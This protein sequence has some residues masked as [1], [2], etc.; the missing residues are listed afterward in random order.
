MSKDIKRIAILVESSRAYGRGLIRG[1]SEFAST[2]QDWQLLYRES[3]MGQHFGDWLE[4]WQGDGIITRINS[5]EEA[6]MIANKGIPAVD[7]YGAFSHPAIS[8]LDA[9]HEAISHVAADFYAHT[10]ISNYAYCGYPGVHFSDVRGTAFEEAVKQQ[11]Q[12]LHIYSSSQPA[13]PSITSHEAWR[14]G[15]EE[16]IA[17]WLHSLPKPVAVFAC[18]DVRALDVSSACR[19]AG[20]RVPE[21]VSIMGVDDDALICSMSIPPLTS[22]KP[23]LIRQGQRGAQIL[24]ELMSERRTEPVT[25]SVLPI[26]VI[27]RPSTDQIVSKYSYV[28]S[29]LRYLRSH[30]H[31]AIGVEDVAEHAG[32]SRSLIDRAFIEELGY[33]VSQEIRRLRLLRIEHLLK[34]TD[35]KLAG[36]AQQTGFSSSTSLSNFFKSVH[37]VSPGKFRETEDLRANADET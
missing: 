11:H 13:E 7:L 28:V 35:M 23:D 37:G 9:D 34:Y 31:K 20:I 12:K 19:L 2:Q 30:I 8:S 4:N 14:S 26:A 32:V 17:K 33:T 21:D 15:R 10:G 25:E 36:I 24:Y 29:A 6:E 1:I 27:E 22:V 18:N 16:E 3:R 5:M